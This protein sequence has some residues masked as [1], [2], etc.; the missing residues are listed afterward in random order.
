MNTWFFLFYRRIILALTFAIPYRFLNSYRQFI[1]AGGDDLL[2]R[3]F[4]LTSESTVV[5]FGGYLGDWSHA[6]NSIYQPKLY[7]V[8]PVDQ[9]C[10]KLRT[11]FQ[12]CANVQILPFA[13]ADHSFKSDIAINGDATSSFGKGTRH[14]IIFEPFEELYKVVSTTTIDLACINIEGGEYDLLDLLIS[15]GHITMFRTLL[16]QF[17]EVDTQSVRL[18][19]DLELRLLQSHNLTF[20][21]PL[22]WQRW[23]RK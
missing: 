17:H 3:G 23:D 2:V 18:R 20:N 10:I 14:P 7:I 5:D 22:V 1:R 19:G 21:Y 15:E 8:E 16:L 13:I 11:R 6:I 4:H 9:F 12:S